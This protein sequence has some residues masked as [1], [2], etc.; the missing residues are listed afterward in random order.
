[1]VKDELFIKCKGASYFENKIAPV[2]SN[3]EM[4]DVLAKAIIE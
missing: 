1:M 2:K 4:Y 3:V